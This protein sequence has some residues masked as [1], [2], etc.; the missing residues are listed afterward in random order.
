MIGQSILYFGREAVHGRVF[1]V[2][3]Y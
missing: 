1:F 3:A 2:E